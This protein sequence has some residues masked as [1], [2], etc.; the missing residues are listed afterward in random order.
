MADFQLLS[1]RIMLAGSKDSVVYRGTH[2][3]LSYPEVLIMQFLHGDEAVSEIAEV[4]T[5]TMSNNDLFHHLQM[6]YPMEAVKECFPGARPNLPVRDDVFHKS[7]AVLMDAQ[8]KREAQREAPGPGP[9]PE[10][11][12][13]P[14][15]TRPSRVPPRRHQ[16]QHQTDRVRRQ[17]EPPAKE[18]EEEKDAGPFAQ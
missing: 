13:I 5:L 2:N 1:C 4:G 8:E 17:E 16:S 14:K 7:R 12:T 11:M 10:N 18:L 15:E 6:T 3:P 9:S